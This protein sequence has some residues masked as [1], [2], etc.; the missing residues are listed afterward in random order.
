MKL[1]QVTASQLNF[2]K[3]PAVLADNIIRVLQK[4]QSTLR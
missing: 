3:S 4:G 1:Y 2:R